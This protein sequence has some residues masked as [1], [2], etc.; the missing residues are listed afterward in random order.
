[1]RPRRK[2]LLKPA[3]SF[4]YLFILLAIIYCAKKFLSQFF[5]ELHLYI[6]IIVLIITSSIVSKLS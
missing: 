5:N 1:M 6:K 2:V 3:L 4:F